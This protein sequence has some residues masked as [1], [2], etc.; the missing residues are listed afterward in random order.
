FHTRRSSEDM[1]AAMALADRALELNPGSARLWNV[2]G[3]IRNAMSQPEVAIAH[4]QKAIQLDPLSP[5]RHQM[6]EATALANMQLGRFPEAISQLREAAD[7]SPMPEPHF[8]MAVCYANLDRVPEARNA[9]DMFEALT[10]SS[11]DTLQWV[12]SNPEFM[13]AL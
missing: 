1:A 7:L 3:W 2:S 8:F 12:Q 4:L 11:A 13:K 6:L 9:R 10:G 5:H